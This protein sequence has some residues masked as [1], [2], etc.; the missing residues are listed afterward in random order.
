MADAVPSWETIV[1]RVTIASNFYKVREAATAWEI[2]F[3]QAHNVRTSLQQLATRSAGSWKG[4]GAEEFRAHLGR[5]DAAI[6]LTVKDHES[7]SHALRACAGHLER[8]VRAIPVPTWMYDK[9]VSS[10]RDYHAAGVVAEV[11]PGAYWTG[12]LQY[13]H[14]QVG[15]DNLASDWLKYAEEWYRNAEAQAQ[16]AY[17]ELCARYGE[18]LAGVPAGTHVPV[19]SVQAGVA[20]P[21]GAS[22]AG[23]VAA[24]PPG[25]GLGQQ[26]A[27]PTAAG[28]PSSAPAMPDLGTVPAPSMDL[29][30]DPSLGTR[31]AGLDPGGLGGAGLGSGG[32]V[33]GLGG[34]G[35]LPPIG[36][37]AIPPLDAMMAAGRG[38]AAPGLGGRGPGAGGAKAGMGAPMGMMPVGG[39]GGHAP[40]DKSGA[41]NTWLHEDDDLFEADPSTPSGVVET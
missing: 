28:T 34:A 31:L 16:K 6:G 32:G 40:A 21:R 8:A 12:L 22:G 41:T 18:E 20:R 25:G 15:S 37:P 33:G 5:V 17:L 26:P 30:L 35:K 1:D 27:M 39:M 19:P 36:P 3:R 13:V 7:V 11:T 29:G 4:G 9:V 2:A 23:R 24:T 10:Q 38:G 14:H